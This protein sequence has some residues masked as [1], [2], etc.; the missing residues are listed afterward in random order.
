MKT[1]YIADDGKQF[2]SKEDC[3]KYEKVLSQQQILFS[4]QIFF[5]DDCMNIIK[6]KNNNDIDIEYLLNE[7]YYIYVPKWTDDI[8]KL[9]CKYITDSTIVYGDIE[10]GSTCYFE[11]NAELN[12]WIDLHSQFIQT[13]NHFNFIKDNINWAIENKRELEYA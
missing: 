8:L 10:Y 6:P 7:T 12:L 13:E 3:V 2:K 1:I 11:Y 9:L 5:L 4:E